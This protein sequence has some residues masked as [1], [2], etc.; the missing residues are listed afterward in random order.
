MRPACRCGSLSASGTSE[1]SKDLILKVIKQLPVAGF[2]LPGANAAGICISWRQVTD[3]WE[4]VKD[5]P[6]HNLY[7][8]SAEGCP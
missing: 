1:S 2:L 7:T 8:I 5:L 6:F 4:P 3:T